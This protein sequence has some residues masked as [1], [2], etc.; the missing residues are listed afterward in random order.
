MKNAAYLEGIRRQFGSVRLKNEFYNLVK[1][2]A[3]G[4]VRMLNDQ[5]LRYP[6]LYLLRPQLVTLA[7]ESYLGP[8]NHRSLELTKELLT[9]G[10]SAHKA[11]EKDL[12]VLRWMLQT[13]YPESDL[14][15]EYD[16]VMD[17]A[18]I[19]L[20]R[21]LRDRISLQPLAELIFRRNR[22]GLNIHDAE[23]A[24][25]ESRDPDCLA[26]VAERIDAPEPKDAALAQKLLAFIPVP[27]ADAGDPG[28]HRQRVLGWIAENKPYLR[29]TGMSSQQGYAPRRFEVDL[30]C[31]YLQ[32]PLA[33]GGAAP[34]LPPAERQ[35]LEEFK[36]LDPAAQALLSEYSHKLRARD[37]ARWAEWMRSSLPEQLASAKNASGG[38]MQ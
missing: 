30:G 36:R 3:R 23:W 7:L 31:K 25:F 16:R 14:G 10:K 18:G 26:M 2:D 8:R 19:L 20:A 12:P 9:H 32:K 1:Q 22:K 5:S 28:R 15:D 24:F 34:A 29:Y 21:E 35:R 33:S 17:R 38:G 27:Q 4:A 37:S 6:L 11:D 13:G